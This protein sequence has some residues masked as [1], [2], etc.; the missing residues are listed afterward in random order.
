MNVSRRSWH[1]WLMKKYSMDATWQGANLCLY[2]WSVVL[3]VA[4]S[5]MLIGLAVLLA[6]GEWLIMSSLWTSYH[7]ETFQNRWRWVIFIV[8]IF[9][10]LILATAYVGLSPQARGS[11]R[12][13]AGLPKKEPSLVWSYLKAWKA[14]VCPLI[15]FK[16]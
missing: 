14:K 8:D 1:Y 10:G 12:L 5:V 9:I 11:R 2:F 13:E 16:D 4:L 15:T 3:C 6:Y 7:I